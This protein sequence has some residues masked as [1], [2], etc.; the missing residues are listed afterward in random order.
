VAA[1]ILRLIALVFLMK[2]SF[3]VLKDANLAGICA[4]LGVA[5]TAFGLSFDTG[6]LW[7]NVR[8][9]KQPRAIS[10]VAATF[11]VMGMICL[12]VAVVVWSVGS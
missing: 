9:L 1:F 3:T 11:D 2:A 8:D 5:L 10:V 6:R 12:G 7:L 4:D